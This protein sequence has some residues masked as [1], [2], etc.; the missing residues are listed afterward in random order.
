MSAADKE[1]T[2]A[3]RYLKQYDEAF[4]GEPDANGPITR[5]FGAV[6]F[7]CNEIDRNDREREEL[8]RL[9][10]DYRAKTALLAAT[11]LIAV[12]LAAATEVFR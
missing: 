12:L 6:I 1:P 9:V 4:A 8:A 7:L 10:S 2:C 3:D 5:L 11:S